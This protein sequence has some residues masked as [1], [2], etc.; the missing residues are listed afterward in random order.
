VC[1]NGGVTGVI[2]G[3]VT[4]TCPFNVDNLNYLAQSLSWYLYLRLSKRDAELFVSTVTGGRDWSGRLIDPNKTMS[5][6][7]ADF[8]PSP[9]AI[10]AALM[11]NGTCS[12]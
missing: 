9:C 4:N 11:G 5:G 2:I 10:G 6:H 3:V 1:Q 12:C 8:T 7:V